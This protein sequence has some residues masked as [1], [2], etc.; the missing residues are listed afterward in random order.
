[1]TKGVTVI[2]GGMGKELQRIGA[3]FGQPEWS[4]LALI[5]DPD[6]VRQA[7]Q[8]FVD[9]GAELIITNTYAVVPYH[10]GPDLFAAR[11][12]E[13]A[14]LAADIARDRRRCLRTSDPGCRVDTAAVWFL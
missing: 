2:D 10:L 7:H 1:M 12:A 11:G 5:E 3:P 9:A 13:L 14:A 6:F 8:N 4:A